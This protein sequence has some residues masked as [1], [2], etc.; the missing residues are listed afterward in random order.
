MEKLDLND[1]YALDRHQQEKLFIEI[2]RRYVNI[3]KA[4]ICSLLE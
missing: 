1:N 4:L 2:V 3:P